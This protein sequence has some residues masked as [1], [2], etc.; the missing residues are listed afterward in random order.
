[1]LHEREVPELCKVVTHIWEHWSNIF[2][3]LDSLDEGTQVCTSIDAKHIDEVL[4]VNE[5][6][7][8]HEIM[9]WPNEHKLI[10]DVDLAVL[11]FLTFEAKPLPSPPKAEKAVKAEKEGS[12]KRLSD[13][14]VLALNEDQFLE[15]FVS[16]DRDLANNA[17]MALT[18]LFAAEVINVAE[19]KGAIWAR[20]ITLMRDGSVQLPAWVNNVTN[21][22]KNKLKDLAAIM[23]Q[24][25]TPRAIRWT[26]AQVVQ[27]EEKVDARVKDPVPEDAIAVDG[28]AGAQPEDKLK[29]EPRA[30]RM[31]ENLSN[32]VSKRGCMR[33][34][35]TTCG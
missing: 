30:Q 2:S 15:E 32:D 13:A 4:Q 16:G 18:R 27:L 12:G 1:V 3:P 5:A 7:M 31:Q 19:G 33:W 21:L 29:K 20:F 11:T 25:D 22:V 14:Q 34:I 9:E 28:I 26:Q 10:K 35:W 17:R 23:A 6:A 8:H 24:E